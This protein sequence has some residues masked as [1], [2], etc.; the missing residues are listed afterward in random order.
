VFFA[1]GTRRAPQGLVGPLARPE[2]APL[3]GSLLAR[4]DVKA[5]RLAQPA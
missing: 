2:D 4:L 3:A 1:G 5:R